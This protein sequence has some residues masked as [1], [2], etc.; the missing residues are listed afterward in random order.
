MA[1]A[2]TASVHILYWVVCTCSWTDPPPVPHRL[3]YFHPELNFF[4]RN[5]QSTEILKVLFVAFFAFILQDRLRMSGNGK[6]RKG[7]T[8]SEGQRVG[9]Y[10]V[11][12]WSLPTNKVFIWSELTGNFDLKDLTSYTELNFQQ[13]VHNWYYGPKWPRCWLLS[14][15][16]NA[17]SCRVGART[18]SALQSGTGEEM[19]MD[20]LWRGL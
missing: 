11:R 18:V 10:Q 12:Y 13:S 17:G 5:Y 15:R 3:S 1:W 8:C 20:R 14:C 6:E 19:C 7:V 2:A 4:L 9:I 16:L